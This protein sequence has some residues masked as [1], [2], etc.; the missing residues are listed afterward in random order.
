MGTENQ[1]NRPSAISQEYSAWNREQ[2]HGKLAENSKIKTEENLTDNER[3]EI[4]KILMPAFSRAVVRKT[5]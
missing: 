2:L 3:Q 4:M 5:N 1:Y